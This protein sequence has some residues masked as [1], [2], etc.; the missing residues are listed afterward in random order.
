MTKLPTPTSTAVLQ[1]CSIQSTYD[2]L[3]WTALALQQLAYVPLTVWA[4]NQIDTP[5][6]TQH[7]VKTGT[8]IYQ[9]RLNQ[10]Q[11][12]TTIIQP[13]FHNS[14]NLSFPQRSSSC[15]QQLDWPQLPA[16][17]I[18]QHPT[19]QPTLSTSNDHLATSTRLDHA[20]YRHH[21]SSCR[22]IQLS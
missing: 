6:L 20:S 18:Q 21:S 15:I 2:S 9:P 5:W 1:Q 16:M 4:S 7:T 14:T 10:H 13:H 11:L 12:P 3:L 17:I 19:S 22:Q 8:S